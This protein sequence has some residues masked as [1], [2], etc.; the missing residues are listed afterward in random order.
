VAACLLRSRDLDYTISRRKW[1]GSVLHEQEKLVIDI[2]L[3]LYRLLNQRVSAQVISSNAEH[4]G[5]GP[6]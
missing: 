3:S 4:D 1:H 2:D 6:L 5:E